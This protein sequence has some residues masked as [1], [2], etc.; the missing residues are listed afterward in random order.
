MK[1]FTVLAMV[2]LA[3]VAVTTNKVRANDP[4]Y[5]ARVR[6][7]EQMVQL[8]IR[9]IYTEARIRVSN[10]ESATR[11]MYWA[12]E[13]SRKVT[14]RG[15]AAIQALQLER[16]RNQGTVTPPVT[17]PVQ[18]PGGVWVYHPYYGWVYYRNQ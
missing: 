16:A 4:L 10:G 14:D 13:E 11:A 3:L 1:K 6:Q 5:Q 7:I 2:T 8:E 15:V 18:Q 12:Q 9:Q 17:P